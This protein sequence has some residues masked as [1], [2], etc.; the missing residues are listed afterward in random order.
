MPI[1][2]RIAQVYLYI[3][4]VYYFF[5]G[6]GALPEDLLP[7]SLNSLLILGAWGTFIGMTPVRFLEFT[8]VFV[9]G[10]KTPYLPWLGI[11]AVVLAVCAFI[12]LKKLKYDFRWIYIWYGLSLLSLAIVID[13]WAY[14]NPWK[15]Y[16]LEVAIGAFYDLLFLLF[17]ISLFTAAF[18]YHRALKKSQLEKNNTV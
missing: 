11:L 8:N 6:I 12:S 3:V 1:R 14:G 7:S 2:A 16:E 5:M 4:T 15:Y 9:N 10:L 13:N 18:I 17:P